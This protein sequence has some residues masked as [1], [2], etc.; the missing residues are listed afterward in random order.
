MRFTSQVEPTIS[1]LEVEA[2][3]NK[4]VFFEP[5]TTETILHGAPNKNNVLKMKRRGLPFSVA[6]AIHVV[7]LTTSFL[8]ALFPSVIKL[9]ETSHWFREGDDNNYDKALEFFTSPQLPFE[10]IFDNPK[11]L[12]RVYFFIIPY[13]FSAFFVLLA[14]IVMSYSDDS[15][16]SR[17]RKKMRHLIGRTI[18]Q[19][20]ISFPKLLVNYFA[21]PA[22]ISVG[23]LI[24]IIIFLIINIGTFAVRVR[25]SLPRGSRKLV[26]LVDPGDDGR[27][28]IRFWS[29]QACEIWGKTLGVL[30]IVNLGWYLIMPIGRRSVFL[31]AMGLSWERSVK[32]H[33]WVGY[34]SV[35]L[36]VIHS[37]MYIAIFIWGNGHPVYDPD[38]VM[39]RHNLFP[40]GCNN[41]H[42][43]DE[44]CS[45]ATKDH[46]RINIYGMITMAL[47]IV[48][49]IFAH[50]WIRRQHFEWFYYTHHL[51]LLVIVFVCLHYSGS[52]MYLLPGLA[53]Y[54]VDKLLVLL[55]FRKSGYVEAKMVSSD[56]VELHVKLGTGITYQTGQWVFLNVPG[57]SHLEWHPF[58]LTSCP[59]VESDKIVFHIKEA[60][61]WTKGVIEETIRNNNNK[62]RVRVDG[63]YGHDIYGQDI[64]PG[65]EGKEAIILV[66][67]GIGVTP[68]MSIA[69]S[70]C[71]TQKTQHVAILWIVRT[72]DE[73]R[74]FE[75]KLREGR[76]LYGARFVVKVWIT[77][78]R[79]EPVPLVIDEEAGEEHEPMTSE[80]LKS[81][82]SEE[83][84][85]HV[86]YTLSSS[87]KLDSKQNKSAYL[88]SHDMIKPFV[89]QHTG[90]SPTINAFVMMMAI[91]VSLVAYAFTQN[92][93]NRFD[94]KPADKLT[95]IELAVFSVVLLSFLLMVAKVRRSLIKQ[96][97]A[98]IHPSIYTDDSSRVEIFRSHDSVTTYDTKAEYCGHDDRYTQLVMRSLLFGR[99]GCRPNMKNEFLKLFPSAQDIGV[100]ACGPVPMV[101]SIN[102]I[103]NVA[104]NKP[105]DGEDGTV[106]SSSNT[107]AWGLRR[108]GG[109]DAFFSF[110]EEEW[111]W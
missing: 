12:M 27:I 78:S 82:S 74:I 73:F 42:D 20:T 87:T 21:F 4:K 101:E 79:P 46:L 64:C 111:E 72:I 92:M 100:L 34:Y 67:G 88:E 33:R 28:P 83:R 22:R 56:V 90:M 10:R 43:E 102:S 55:W 71:K 44:W 17:S 95:L 36:M 9:Y 80:K 103:C 93:N 32:Y 5:S 35:I 62:L 18:L 98:K 13:I 104:P 110:T 106:M 23:E 25:R 51:F 37:I 65:L 94:I 86:M 91:F 14:N 26:F 7:L 11:V 38:G 1:P 19:R 85:Q 52:M 50:P 16:P 57:V 96:E 54:G 2:A 59:Q 99:I 84:F 45:D 81:M 48:M 40:W 105:K 24:G 6:K 76:R 77:M 70:L 41:P 60:G 29:W 47:I 69:F 97:D 68:M 63:F 53:I 108:K 89:L 75:S 66:G 39:I 61:S 49:T 58:S 109:P 8:C 30:T 31:E 15:R 3:P 107:A